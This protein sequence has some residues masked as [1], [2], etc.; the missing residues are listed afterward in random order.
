[1]LRPFCTADNSRCRFAARHPKSGFFQGGPILRWPLT[2]RLF[3]AQ[4]EIEGC[5]GCLNFP[6]PEIAKRR[7]PTRAAFIHPRMS[8]F[9]SRCNNPSF[10]GAH[11]A[12]AARSPYC[13]YTVMA[14]IP[15]D[16]FW[17]RCFRASPALG[18]GGGRTIAWRSRQWQRCTA[19]HYPARIKPDNVILEGGRIAETD[20]SWVFGP[21][22]E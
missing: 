12:A 21:G 20:R 16:N 6:Q 5:P 3:G 22:R 17:R 4:D 8:W 7:T 19:R 9:G 10:G 18:I 15:G 11:R 14:A 2:T 1:M 13:L